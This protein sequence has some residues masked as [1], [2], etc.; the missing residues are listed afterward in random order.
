MRHLMM[1]FA[2]ILCAGALAAELNE[3]VKILAGGEPID[4]DVG[5]AAPWLHD[6]NGNGKLDLLVGEFGTRPDPNTHA[7]RLRIY[8]NVGTNEKPKYEGFEYFQAG[9]E[10]ARVPTG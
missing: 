2:A 6:M 3:P 10:D 9:G 1:A 5:H 7:G 8:Y 4:V